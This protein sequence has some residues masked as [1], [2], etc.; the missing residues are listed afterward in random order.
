MNTPHNST[1]T[2]DLVK[3]RTHEWLEKA[4]IGLNFCPFAKS[5]YVKQQVH[6]VI[7]RAAD[8]DT[9]LLELQTELEALNKSDPQ[10]RDTTLLVLPDSFKDFLAFNDFIDFTDELLRIMGLTGT[11]QIAHFH[12]QF[13]FANTEP[14]DISN[15]T[16]RA[17]Y[18]IVHLLRESSIDRAV[19][20]FSDA[21]EIYERN[22]QTLNALG[23][24]GW[25]ALFNRSPSA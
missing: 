12:P 24:A 20:S 11:L 14:D 1:D 18:P 4:V 19:A 17:P 9:I 10:Q 22:I 23:R 6:T 8:A 5:V 25:Q 15:Y 21:S 3:A 13:Q 16:N 7:S 2:D